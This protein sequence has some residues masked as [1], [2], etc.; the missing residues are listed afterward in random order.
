MCHFESAGLP[1]N[2]RE[3][4]SFNKGFAT[5]DVGKGTGLG[6]SISHGIIQ[7]HNGTIDVDSEVGVGTT[8]TIRLPI[9]G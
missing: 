2:Q 3:A 1:P 8:F 4:L 7:K 5:K 9:D 6:L